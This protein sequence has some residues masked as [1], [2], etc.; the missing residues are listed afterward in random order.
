MNSPVV[1]PNT[2]RKALVCVCM[3]WILFPTC[4][5]PALLS[6]FL[7][8][9][10]STYYYTVFRDILCMDFVCEISFNI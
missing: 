8:Q 7:I 1:R 9:S 3:C 4:I 10:K 5:R 6:I 2:C